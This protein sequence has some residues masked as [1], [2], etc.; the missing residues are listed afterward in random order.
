MGISFESF[1]VFA[2]AVMGFIVAARN[3]GQRLVTTAVAVSL[4]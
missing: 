1:G 3:A 2:A 4:C